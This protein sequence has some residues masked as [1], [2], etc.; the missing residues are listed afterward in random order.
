M[1]E[2]KITDRQVRR[3]VILESFAASALFMP[4][5][6]ARV[7]HGA[8]MIMLMGVMVAFVFGAF[9]IWVSG[10]Q[11]CFT[12]VQ[13][14]DGRLIHLLYALRFFLRGVVYLLVFV[15]MVKQFLLPE[16][17]RMMIA[18]PVVLVACYACL[19]TLAG[20]A[21]LIELLFWWVLVPVI[22]IWLL[23]L[24]G[25]NWE[26]LSTQSFAAVG[27]RPGQTVYRVYE[28]LIFYLPF[29]GLLYFMPQTKAVKSQGNHQE[30]QIE[31]NQTQKAA[32]CG[33]VTGLVLNL[34]IFCMAFLTIGE[35]GL[36]ADYFSVCNMLKTVQAPGD[37]VARLDIAAMPFLMIG[38]FI[39]YSGSIFYGCKAWEK[40]GIS[41]RFASHGWLLPVT[42]SI[43]IFII[44]L[45]LNSFHEVVEWYIEYAVWIDLPLAVILPLICMAGMRVRKSDDNMNKDKADRKNKKRFVQHMFMLGFVILSFN[46]LTGCSKVDIE[47]R[48]YVLMLGVDDKSDDL[49]DLKI[50]YTYAAAMA[51]MQ[52]YKAE[53]GESVKMKTAVEERDSL[54]AFRD[55]YSRNHAT[56]M[57][58]GHVKLLLFQEK[59][60]EQPDRLSELLA[61]WE[62]EDLLSST[63]MVAAT[64]EDAR[65][66]ISLDEESEL[67]LSVAIVNMLEKEGNVSV[68]LQD[69]YLTYGEG[70]PLVL[71]VL[72][73]SGEEEFPE[74]VSY[75]TVEK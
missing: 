37:V 54:M 2:M 14:I 20:R 38:L 59:L 50:R 9:F 27:V 8:V 68:T 24:S 4:V 28:M 41:Q 70:E 7:S 32:Y 75:V 52:G 30:K 10:R 17:S 26:L 34:A 21:R 44:L 11:G 51:D 72:E 5:V 63:V 58:F 60:L 48:D 45:F 18:I 39:L 61:A 65:E 29:E 1:E 56:E 19:R 23:S 66:Y 71:P 46:L 62:E 3:M 67:V 22:L 47:D 42:V 25:W 49:T 12:G 43:M 55:S 73:I 6:A 53:V 64:R 31:Q 15:Q 35:H 57:D 33:L 40:V 13:A 69:L 36:R 16:S 74:I